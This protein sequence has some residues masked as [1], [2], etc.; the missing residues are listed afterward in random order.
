MGSPLYMAPE[1]ARGRKNIDHRADL[2]SLGVV[3]YQ[4][5]SG[6]TPFHDIQALGELII[7]ICGD[8]I[9]PLQSFAPWVSPEIAHAVHAALQINPAARFQSAADMLAAIMPLIPDGYRLSKTELRGVTAG[10]R[11][12]EAPKFDLT[13][14]QTGTDLAREAMAGDG[15][16][17]E[18]PSEPKPEPE[19]PPAEVREATHD[20]MAQTAAPA[21]STA[22]G[23]LHLFALTAAIAALIVG[24]WYALRGE[25]TP[26]VSPQAS[27]APTSTATAMS[28]S[29]DKP[30][31]ILGDS[32]SGYSTFRLASFNKALATAGVAVRY[33]E[34]VDQAAR[35]KKLSDG[36]ADLMVTS[37]DQFL[38]HKPKG[39]IVAIIDTT[40]GADAVV[41]N[42]KRY[43]ELS[44]LEAL[45]QQ[46]N[47]T[48]DTG[49]KLQ[50][51]FA[52]GT[53]SEYLAMVLDARFESFDLSAFDKVVVD[54]AR[55]AWTKLSADDSA[56]AVAVL[57]EPFVEKARLAGY[58][59]VLSSADVPNSIVDVLVASDRLIAGGSE[60]LEQVVQTYYRRIEQGI[61]RRGTLT[62]QI[63][64]DSNLTEQDAHAVVEGI[65]FFSAVAAHRWLADGEL[66]KRI[67]ST[68]AIL[69]LVGGLEAPPPDRA[70]LFDARYVTAAAAQ[71][72][73]LIDSIRDEQPKLAARLEGAQR[74]GAGG[75]VDPEQLRGA[76][77]LG[78]LGQATFE[79]GGDSLDPAGQ[80]V[81]DDAVGRIADFNTLTTVVVLSGRGADRAAGTERA[82]A[83]KQALANKGVVHRMAVES[84]GAKGPGEQDRVTIKLVRAP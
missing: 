62:Q 14:I 22:R 60:T 36:E 35:A 64:D 39:K 78:N 68:A 77:V 69:T 73:K 79:L 84:L 45:E 11:S 81:L 17:K 57:W 61:T 74:L 72:R 5:L 82:K 2:W 59:V 70:A 29:A 42:N 44:T 7:A 34:E 10:E 25:Q 21:A 23:K 24:G 19:A 9:P 4:L 67:A 15:D 41:L 52:G 13:G 3:A 16:A 80:K 12:E 37:L 75:D 46:V 48:A 1:Q 30:L 54:D 28:F 63:A 33:Q 8:E 58:N 51:C 18:S 65:Q 43:P 50:L 40:V 26:S 31:T 83:V 66:D 38:S 76:A 71:T 47:N 20:G 49:K 6:R 32:F 27:A 53:P 56:L 55:E